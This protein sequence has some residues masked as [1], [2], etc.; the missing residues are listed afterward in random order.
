M[1]PQTSTLSQARMAYHHATVTVMNNTEIK[2]QSYS[3]YWNYA[4]D[5]QAKVA[6]IYGAP[7]SQLSHNSNSNN[8]SCRPITDK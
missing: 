3:H 7:K 8:I 2:T 4:A 5:T 1:Y 6:N